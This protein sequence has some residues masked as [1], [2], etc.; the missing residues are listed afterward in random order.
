[1][2][3]YIQLNP[4]AKDYILKIS[5]LKTMMYCGVLWGLYQPELNGWAIQ[6]DHAD[7]IFPFWLSALQALQHAHIHCPQYIPKKITAKDFEQSLL[8]TLM[9]LNVTPT[10]FHHQTRR[11][12]LTQSDMQQLFFNHTALQPSWS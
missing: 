6:S 1:M 10:L 9:R 5:I 4:T 2:K 11:F 7:H 3:T 12:K 8:P